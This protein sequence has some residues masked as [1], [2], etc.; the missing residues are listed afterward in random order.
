MNEVLTRAEMEAQFNG[1]W[2]LVADPELDTDREVIRGVVAF[3]GTDREAMYDCDESLQL[4]HAA[5]L[6]FGPV[7]KMRVWLNYWS[8]SAFECPI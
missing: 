6:Y 2:V 5:Y 7:P 4:K 1:E 8:Q 3:H